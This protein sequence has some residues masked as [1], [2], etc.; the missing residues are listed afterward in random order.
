V[1]GSRRVGKD[2]TDRQA[3]GRANGRT[4]LTARLMRKDGGTHR[5]CAHLAP[6]AKAHD[7]EGSGPL[8]AQ[9]GDG[10]VDVKLDVPV[11]REPVDPVHQLVAVWGRELVHG[12]RLAPEGIG[13][14]HKEA[15]ARKLIRH[16]H[17]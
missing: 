13:E 17:R 5:E 11:V 2:R 3:R 10:C 1:G 12:P 15:R 9:G 7:A 8:G 14:A 16:L 4:A 6:P